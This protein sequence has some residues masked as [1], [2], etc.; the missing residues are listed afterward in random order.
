M[1]AANNRIQGQTRAAFVGVVLFVL[2]SV[3]GSTADAQEA[4]SVDRACGYYAPAE[5][6]DLYLFAS[7]R[8]VESLVRDL[9]P[10]DVQS[11]FSLRAANVSHAVAAIRGEERYVLYDQYLYASQDAGGDDRWKLL[12]ILAHQIGHHVLGHDLSATADRRIQ[13][14]LAADAF[15]AKAMRRFGAPRPAATS[16]FAKAPPAPARNYPET[17]RRIDQI[18]AAWEE[19]DT[20]DSLAFTDSSESNVP[21]F[22]WPPPRPSARANLPDSLWA[23]QHPKARLADVAEFLEEA[24]ERAGYGTRSFYSVPKGFALVAQLERIESDGSPFA[25]DRRWST[26]IASGRL[27]SLSTY[28]QALFTAPEGRFRIIVFVVTNEPFSH[29]GDRV[30]F[31]VAKDWLWHGTNKLP[32]SVG[33]ARYTEDYFCTALIYEFVVSKQ[34]DRAHVSDPSSVPARVHLQKSRIW[35]YLRH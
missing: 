3:V 10:G 6:D 2:S 35:E 12:A 17:A 14:E 30:S 31:K 15:S 13:Q 32:P 11:D 9:L 20:S 16:A 23:P 25:E 27:F 8:E 24:F 18:N 29:T 7:D 33:I 21:V 4:V 1:S 5:R 26:D 28:L 22:Q 19:A 34:P